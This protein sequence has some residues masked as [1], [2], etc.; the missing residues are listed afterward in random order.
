MYFLRDEYIIEIGKKKRSVYNMQLFG[1]P[2]DDQYENA[3]NVEW[4]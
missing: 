3:G 2:T 1:I 4:F